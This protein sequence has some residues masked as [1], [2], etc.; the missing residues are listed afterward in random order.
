[1]SLN[2]RALPICGQAIAWPMASSWRTWFRSWCT[3]SVTISPAVRRPTTLCR[4]ARA[5]SSRVSRRTRS[6]PSARSGRNS[7]SSS[8][9][10]FAQSPRA[11]ATLGWSQPRNVG[12]RSA[13]SVRIRPVK[14]R[15]SASTRCPTTSLAHHSPGAGRQR[16]PAAPSAL[17]SA[18]TVVAVAASS[19]AMRPGS[20]SGASGWPTAMSNLRGVDLRTR[21]EVQSTLPV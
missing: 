11:A 10:D 8:S 14:P 18:S 13:R 5:R 1:M 17:S 3:H 12:S 2:R 4:P 6:I 20:R 15:R 9:A 16:A 7:A 19:C 21:V